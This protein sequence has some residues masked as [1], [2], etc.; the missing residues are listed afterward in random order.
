MVKKGSM[1]PV[2]RASRAEM[3]MKLA[4]MG[5]IAPID[6]YNDLGYGDAERRL[7]HLA[8]FHQGQ[9]IPTENTPQ[10]QQLERLRKLML[11]PEFKKLPDNQK[12]QII[13]QA[14]QIIEAIK[15]QQEE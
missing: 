10:G 7:M 6:V 13:Q 1:L 5:I 4:G 9:L 12:E 3:A 8:E 11:S 15:G 14:R 2:D